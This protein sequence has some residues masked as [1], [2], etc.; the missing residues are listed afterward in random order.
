MSYGAVFPSSQPGY[1]KA[2]GDD[3]DE[4]RWIE[5]AKADARTIEKIETAFFRQLRK[6]FVIT[7]V[8][9]V[10]VGA[11]MW[12]RAHPSSTIARCAVP[13]FALSAALRDA[14]GGAKPIALP[15]D[16]YLLQS[17]THAALNATAPPS[18]V[19]SWVAQ[20]S[21]AW[22]PAGITLEIRRLRYV[23]PRDPQ[24]FLRVMRQQEPPG[25]TGDG[26]SGGDGAPG[27]GA[28]GAYGKELQDALLSL[29]GAEEAGAKPRVPWSLWVLHS[30]PTCGAAS[31]ASAT[32]GS[33]FLRETGC[34]SVSVDV[35]DT[36][37]TQAVTIAHELGHT[38]GLTDH[39]PDCNMMSERVTGVELNQRQV[40]R[41]ARHYAQLGRPFAA[42][43]TPF[44]GVKTLLPDMG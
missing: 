34:A 17:R 6:A 26:G 14:G 24:P 29:Q 33:V 40:L 2:E 19:R 15:V 35:Y 37:A 27:A 5:I 44:Q 12:S 25:T 21:E 32:R 31:T 30:M 42:G 41:Y 4:R 28:P 43:D 11:A 9:G 20:A 8:L 1:S 36:L 3:D 18:M 22:H 10:M 38:F 16:V 13:T 7:A 23:E 39:A